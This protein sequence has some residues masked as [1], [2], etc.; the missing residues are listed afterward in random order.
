V[1]SAVEYQVLARGGQAASALR[2]T[3]E[4]CCS[5]FETLMGSHA[6]RLC[7]PWAFARGADT[8]TSQKCSAWLPN[9]LF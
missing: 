1:R 7:E 6:E 5:R 9:M 3:L 2:A 8:D 4:G